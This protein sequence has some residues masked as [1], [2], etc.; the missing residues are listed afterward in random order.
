MI[1]SRLITLFPPRPQEGEAT[2]TMGSR[3]SMTLFQL[4]L[5]L[6]RS[7]MYIKSSWF[8]SIISISWLGV[9]AVTLTGTLGWLLRKEFSIWGSFEKHRDSSVPT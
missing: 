8:L 5:Y 6:G 2:N 3:T 1:S 9:E 4:S 7:R